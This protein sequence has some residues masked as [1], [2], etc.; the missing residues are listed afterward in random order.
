MSTTAL[1]HTRRTLQELCPSYDVR[2]TSATELAL[3]P[4]QSTTSLVVI[5]GGRDLPYVEEMGKMRRR[6]Y[7]G[8]TSAQDEI[9]R[10]VLEQG[11][12]FVGICAGAY[13]ASSFCSFEQ[14]TDME[15]AGP[16]SGLQFYPGE[17]RGTV[18]SGFVYES[19]A[20]AR[21]VRLAHDDGRVAMHYNGGGA[22]IDANQY[23]GQ[24]VSV[25]ASYPSDELEMAHADGQRSYASQAAI[26]H[27][28]A[29]SG[30]AIL[31]G[32]HPE[33]SLLPE[34]RPVQLTTAPSKLSLYGTQS[35]GDDVRAEV[36][37]QTVLY[38]DELVAEDEQRRRFLASCLQQLGLKTH[39][40]SASHEPSA[41]SEE[42]AAQGQL[43]HITV[44]GASDAVRS[45]LDSLSQ[46][47]AG[48]QVP[49]P[50]LSNIGSS[51]AGVCTHYLFSVKD[52]NDVF[53]F[54]SDAGSVPSLCDSAAY[55]EFKDAETGEVDLHRV[56][57]YIVIQAVDDASSTASVS[58]HWDSRAYLFHLDTS[59]QRLQGAKLSSPRDPRLGHILQYGERVTSTQTMLD[60]NPKLMSQLPTGFVSFATHQILG[61]GRSGNSWI[62]PL[63]CL[64][65]S[66][67]L[68]IPPRNAQYAALGGNPMTVGPKLVFVQ[69]LAGLAIVDAVRRGLGEEYAN[70]GRRIR[71]KW[72]N[73]IY[74]EVT[75]SSKQIHKGTFEHLGKT[76]AKMGGILVNSQYLHGSWSLVVGC[77]VNCLNA[78]P[79][80]SLSALVNEENQRRQ[81]EARA[82]DSM[83]RLTVLPSVSQE[84]LGGAVL[85]SFEC[86]WS[87][88]V[89]MGGWDK[90]LAA[91]Y[92]SAWLHGDQVTTLTTVD[93]PVQVRIVGISP[94]SG[95][96]R[97]VPL[98]DVVGFGVG[99]T[100][101]DGQ[102]WGPSPLC[103]S[104]SALPWWELRPDGN[105]FD[106]LQNLIKTK[107]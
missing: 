89:L 50:H 39:V 64:Q 102:S 37:K 80:T 30:Q 71:L 53:H 15:V 43:S 97:A 60:K 16:R 54:F 34:S 47:S 51:S 20:G 22:F 93:P 69:Y 55:E 100:S 42:L 68:H 75:A 29:G 61:R 78:L 107:T 35:E 2:P 26:V 41:S 8:M 14:G 88:F 32:T 1:A 62:S 95:T 10:W 63:G 23:V 65:F 91:A 76:W 82:S 31:F 19:D 83:S 7:G 79:A 56:P 72:P 92:S 36:S 46:L 66:L 103:R 24:G 58:R 45:S 59:R 101:Q 96:L 104:P 11:G 4:W 25:L 27:C 13:F 5:P 94:E 3:A 49:A 57:K 106:M 74:A 12:S 38:C 90:E 21:V 9:R 67:V 86:L 33:F 85:A 99:L 48:D 84:R 73:D 105:S 17:C 98:P 18:Y 52:N 40:H 70:V 44:V 87:R 6:E 28:R 77:G 81:Q